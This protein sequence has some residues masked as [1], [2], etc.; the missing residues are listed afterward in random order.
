M[1]ADGFFRSFWAIALSAPLYTYALLGT[2]RAAQSLPDVEGKQVSLLVFLA[3][4]AL[5]FL[6]GSIVFLV[7]MMPLSRMLELQ[8]RYTQFA[9]SYNWGTFALNLAGIVPVLAFGTGLIAAAD[10]LAFSYVILGFGIYLRFASLHLAL[11]AEWPIAASL[12]M[13]EGLMRW[14]WWLLLLSLV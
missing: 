8:S 12:A 7:A 3:L 14:I 6:G 2:M 13:T 5:N 10:S 1:T 4:H 11:G 9:V